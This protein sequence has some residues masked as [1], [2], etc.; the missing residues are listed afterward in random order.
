MAV[1]ESR[2]IVVAVDCP[3]GKESIQ[4]MD[5]S[6]AAVCVTGSGKGIDVAEVCGN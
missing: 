6:A 1:V 3:S 4:G 2:Y 5:S